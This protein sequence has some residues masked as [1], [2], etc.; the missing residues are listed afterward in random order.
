MSWQTLLKNPARKKAKVTESGDVT[1]GKYVV[2]FNSYEGR[3]LDALT[4]NAETDNILRK[5]KDGELKAGSVRRAIN[6]L[7]KIFDLPMTRQ[8]VAFEKIPTIDIPVQSTVLANADKILDE[9]PAS[10]HEKGS[11][12]HTKRKVSTVSVKKYEDFMKGNHQ[13]LI[14]FLT[15]GTA[16]AKKF[17]HVEIR[18]WNDENN[19]RLVKYLKGAAANKEHLMG[20][21]TEGI[22]LK[23][24]ELPPGA[25][26]KGVEEI[27]EGYLITLGPFMSIFNGKKYRNGEPSSPIKRNFFA[28]LFKQPKYRTQSVSAAVSGVETQEVSDDIAKEYLGL[29]LYKLSGATRNEFLPEI[30]NL[31]DMSKIYGTK[32]S[33]KTSTGKLLPALEY[34]LENTS[35]QLEGS[36]AKEQTKSSLQRKTAIDQLLRGEHRSEHRELQELFDKTVKPAVKAKGGRVEAKREL[37][38][39]IKIVSEDTELSDA[40]EE[41]TGKTVIRRF[42]MP[43]ELRE[44]LLSP[45]RSKVNMDIIREHSLDHI[46]PSKISVKNM[47]S[48]MKEAIQRMEPSR[49][50]PDSHHEALPSDV[51]RLKPLFTEVVE[52]PYE[53]F[54]EEVRTMTE[55]EALQSHGRFSQAKFRK[56][57]EKMDTNVLNFPDVVF[58]LGR[59]ER[60][61]LNE[62][63]INKTLRQTTRKIFRN[64]EADES[65]KA[66]REELKQK[67]PRIREEFVSKLKE[68]IGEVLS[69]PITHDK[70]G[71]QPYEW[72]TK[73]KGIGA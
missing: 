72:L 22:T 63:E 56:E 1:T 4:D 39:F 26:K 21:D 58:L 27:P 12:Y 32:E 51:E 65:V 68:K 40:F 35:F 29:V 14:D 45:T 25:K 66:L 19:D 11:T 20:Y 49:V 3:L 67:Y 16:S 46:Y 55:N 47:D 38:K 59:M 30:A 10:R 50:W 15:Q 54:I 33:T 60:I 69:E 5:V 7:K 18:R 64:D 34:I 53:S 42:A 36:F 43:N 37:N 6:R 57:M 31:E 17:R 24:A 2:E 48:D 28:K 70:S 8:R 23:L 44:T 41:I 71:F 13:Q 62:S 9:L 52:N 73:E 61:L